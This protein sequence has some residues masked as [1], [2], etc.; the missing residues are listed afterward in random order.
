MIGSLEHEEFMETRA[1]SRSQD[2]KV[3]MGHVGLPSLHVIV[4]HILEME[5]PQNP[6]M[7]SQKTGHF[8]QTQPNVGS[9][10]MLT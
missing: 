10:R 2:E 5:E 4:E 7:V 1:G 3:D 9:G 6:D 8:E